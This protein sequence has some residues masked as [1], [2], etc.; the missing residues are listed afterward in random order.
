MTH[1]IFSKIVH[2]HIPSPKLYE[3]HHL[4][5]FLHIT[6][7]TK[8]HTLLIPKIHKQNIYHITPEV[9]NYYFQPIP[10]IPTAIKQQFQP[11]P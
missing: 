3:H 6:Q 9:S 1:S 7:L 2:P 4:F 5:P 10:K 11:I 8:P